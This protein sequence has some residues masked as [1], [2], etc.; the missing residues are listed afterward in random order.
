[1]RKWLGVGVSLLAMETWASSPTM[2]FDVLT[3]SRKCER[4]KYGDE[5]TVCTYR[6]T[7][8]FLLELDGVGTEQVV[9]S[10]LEASMDSGL[11]A[12]FDVKS[13][14]V[15]VRSGSKGPMGTVY[16]STRDGQVYR[17]LGDC[18]TQKRD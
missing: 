7:T 6:A 10:V 9:V 11:F 18:Q 8:G 16:I 15:T 5:A 14:C 17:N 4:K 12:S 2:T 13:T 3:R 1:M